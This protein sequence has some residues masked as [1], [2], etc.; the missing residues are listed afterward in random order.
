MFRIGFVVQNKCDAI[1][2]GYGRIEECLTASNNGYETDFL[3][4]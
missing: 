4:T 3:I 2:D 1:E